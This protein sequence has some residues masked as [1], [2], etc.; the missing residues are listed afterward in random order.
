MKNLK[1]ILA[2]IAV[3][4]LVGLYIVTLIVAV[5]GGEGSQQLFMACIV[6][7]VVIPCLM[8]I[9]N[10]VYG[11]MGKQAKEDRQRWEDEIAAA[12]GRKEEAAAGSEED[13]DS[14]R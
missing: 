2:L 7:T 1:R 8:Y 14:A 4:L 12:A 6:A 5:A 11:L 10:W 13:D 9:I 3:I